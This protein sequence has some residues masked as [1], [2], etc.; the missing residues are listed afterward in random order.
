MV[1]DDGPLCGTRTPTLTP[2]YRGSLVWDNKTHSPPSNYS[3]NNFRIIGFPNALRVVLFFF[4]SFCSTLTLIKNNIIHRQ[5]IQNAFSKANDET[6][7]W[8]RIRTSMW[9]WR[10]YCGILDGDQWN[11]YDVLLR[12]EN[13]FC[14]ELSW[15][16]G[17]QWNRQR[18]CQH[19]SR[20]LQYN[21]CLTLNNALANE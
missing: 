3:A 21:E 2:N 16:S 9:A 14:G 12:G 13:S 18:F 1:D 6:N 8:V 10:S 5:Q 17:K 4:D 20:R 15:W 19:P 7:W 11:K